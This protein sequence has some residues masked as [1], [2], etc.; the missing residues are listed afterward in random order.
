MLKI[1]K[2]LRRH[3]VKHFKAA[4][5]STD[6][7]I[8][9]LYSERLMKGAITVAGI[10]EIEAG[11][12]PAPAPTPAKK[13]KSAAPAPTPAAAPDVSK[14]IE[15]GIA[16]ALRAHGVIDR[17]GD[18]SPSA[19]FTKTTRIRVKEASERYSR[20]KTGAVYPA[21]S[22]ST[23]TPH[24]M[25]GQPVR[26]GVDNQTF[27][28]P[29]DLDKAVALAFVK[30]QANKNPEGGGELPRWLRMTDHDRELLLYA[31]H[32]EKWTGCIETANGNETYLQRQ[33]LD[34]WHIKT[35]L[36]D[37]NSGGIEITPVVFDDAL[38][39][40]PV[41]YGELFP[42]VN[43]QTVSKGRR[44]KGGA[45]VNPEFTSGTG[46]GTAI[47]PFSTSNFV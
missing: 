46:E 19:A 32:E 47:M 3:A 18:V 24:P 33:K 45:M 4:D 10:R 1:T 27:D 35:L 11:T 17:P 41:L 26:L 23:N 9:K 20:T 22:R 7:E 37:T 39:L 29:S 12:A 28:H 2:R 14:L 34:S 40:T 25:A 36:D 13:K 8:R 5:T 30:Y 43:V 38:V 15:K 42:F 31:A 6:Q 44:V 21:F 16:D